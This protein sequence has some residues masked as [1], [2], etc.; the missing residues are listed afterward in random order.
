MKKI[1]M[2]FVAVLCCIVLAMPV[3]VTWAATS[4]QT[5]STLCETDVKTASANCSLVGVEGAYIK[6]TK[7]ILSKINSMRKQACENGV[8]NP[9]NPDV[10]LT[11][12]DYRPVKWSKDLGS[13]AKIRAAELSLVWGY[14]RP[15]GKMW[16]DVW[17]G[18]KNKVKSSRELIAKG[19]FSDA[20][21]QW[22]AQKDSNYSQ[23]INPKNLY[24]GV[25]TFTN[26][27]TKKNT[28][29]IEFSTEDTNT[30][31]I[32]DDP[33]KD[34]NNSSVKGVQ[35]IELEKD[36]IL[37]SVSLDKNTAEIKDK[38]IKAKV[39]AQVNNNDKRKI[40]FLEKS[41]IKWNSSDTDVATVQDTST[42]D[43]SNKFYNLSG[44]VTIKNA[45]GCD[46]EFKK[47]DDIKASAYLR[48]THTHKWDNGKVVTP[49]TCE[50]PG[51]TVYTCTVCGQTRTDETVPRKT[52]HKHTEIKGAKSATCEKEGYTGDTYC[53]DCGKKIA[54]GEKIPATGHQW[55]E[56]VIVPATENKQGKATYTCTVCG[57][58][59]TRVIPATG[60]DG[61]KTELRNQKDPTCETE[62]YT[63]D[64][65]YV[66]G[67]KKLAS[68]EKIP[69]KGHSWD[70]GKVTTEAKCEQDGVRT[71]TCTVCGKTRTEA[72]PATGHK[73][74]EIKNVKEATCEEAGYTGDTCC[75]ACGKVLKQGETIPAKGHLWDAG[76]ITKEAKCE[77]KGTKTYTCSVCGKTKTEDIPATG[78]QNKQI[79]NQKA[80]TC[81]EAGYTGDTYCTDCGKELVQ[82]QTIPATGHTWNN[83]IVTKKA[84]TKTA[85]VK[86]YACISCGKTKTVTIPIIKEKNVTISG[87]VYKLKGSEASFIQAKKDAAS[88]TIPST[89]KADGIT[90]KVTSIAKKAFNGNKKLTK[91][92]IGANVKSISTD[93][94]YKCP[95]LKSV[96]IKTVLLKKGKASKKCF[97]KVNKKLTLTV[98][99]KVKKTYQAIFKGLRVK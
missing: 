91:V 33:A 54:D 13:S 31:D 24:V 51:K 19:S 4:K 89:V 30:N 26:S 56:K 62:G 68:G 78:H 8:P 99:K 38:K 43:A 90:Y 36:L 96:D 25:G 64:T 61:R 60:T 92:T 46:I 16:S 44:K 82:G 49:A 35:K 45:G 70:A 28:T 57:K 3:Q 14:V 50:K 11:S 17:S 75:K 20:L 37:C 85:G 10:K 76:K 73:E 59:E 94:F 79:K 23:L 41:N 86:T 63:G 12:N 34:A 48:V 22:E 53:K 6:Q 69:A 88:V 9:E 65:Y 1:V 52:G 2:S 80:P 81:E 97:N 95:A 15:N 39:V 66:G 55:S 98:P 27:E 58:T 72:I 71:F 7:A 18:S 47:G 29:S 21:E 42:Q 77:E 32:T 74:T 5:E 40:V 84:T 93:A 87:H 83:G 67:D